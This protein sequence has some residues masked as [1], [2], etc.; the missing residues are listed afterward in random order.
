MSYR[1]KRLWEASIEN[2]VYVD[3][4]IPETHFDPF[5]ANDVEAEYL[6][7]FKAYGRVENMHW[8]DPFVGEI[9]KF[10]RMANHGGSG[11]PLLIPCGHCLYAEFPLSVTEPISLKHALRN[12]ISSIPPEEFNNPE[13]E[14]YIGVMEGSFNSGGLN[15][16]GS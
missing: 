1:L 13:G 9:I 6:Y 15:I 11:S 10:Q 4:V 16:E 3:I 12:V 8:A 5:T 2:G 7:R 14:F